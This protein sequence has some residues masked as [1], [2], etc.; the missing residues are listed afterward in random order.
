MGS[1][2][3]PTSF[4]KASRYSCLTTTVRTSFAVCDRSVIGF[5]SFVTVVLPFTA[6]KLFGEKDQ[7][8]GPQSPRLRPGPLRGKLITTSPRTDF[9]AVCAVPPRAV[10]S[11][12]PSRAPQRRGVDGVRLVFQR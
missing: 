2:C 3:N 12:T 1:M 5:F 8:S 4:R 6:A 11:I 7:R 9:D 10:F